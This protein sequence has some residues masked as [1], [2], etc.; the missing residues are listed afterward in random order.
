ML[1][2][3]T[4]QVGPTNRRQT[5]PHDLDAN[6]RWGYRYENL[7]VEIIG[8]CERCDGFDLK[9]PFHLSV[10]WLVG[11]WFFSLFVCLSLAAGAPED[12]A[13]GGILAL[14]ETMD[15][16]QEEQLKQ[17]REMQRLEVR[18]L[19]WIYRLYLVGAESHGYAHAVHA[20]SSAPVVHH[21]LCSHVNS[22]L[23]VFTGFFL[24]L[25]KKML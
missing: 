23:L 5:C 13:G 9:N 24:A 17:Q 7:S 19:T 8:S 18:D 25:G 6:D 10:G 11:W 14:P 2:R 3:T 21:S 1:S 22:L 4:S 12:G 16:D 15:K 20:F